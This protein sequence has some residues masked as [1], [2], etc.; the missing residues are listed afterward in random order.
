M[1]LLEQ[2]WTWYPGLNKLKEVKNRMKWIYKNRSNN[3]F[4][5]KKEKKNTKLLM[6]VE[7]KELQSGKRDK[8]SRYKQIY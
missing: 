5:D 1:E 7:D 3:M 8:T 6:Q 4:N 2:F